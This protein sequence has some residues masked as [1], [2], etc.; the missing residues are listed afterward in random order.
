MAA[1]E[2]RRNE[3]ETLARGSLEGERRASIA[4]VAMVVL[5]AACT[6][7]LPRLRGEEVARDLA[8]QAVG[9]GYMVFAIGAMFALR[10]AGPN[11]R[12][13]RRRP[14]VVTVLDFA[15]I[16]FMGL[17]DV[18]GA[19]GYR[20]ELGA[21]ASSILI[22][23][24]VAR[25]SLWHVVLSVGLAI[26]AFLTIAIH[27]GHA[28]DVGTFFV[29]GG[30]LAL[31]VLVALT[32]RAVRAM[33][34]DL[35]RRDNLTRFLPRPVAERV[36]AQGT[37][38]LAPVMREVT[39]LFSD[40]RGFTTLSETLPPRAV[41]E[42]LDD[43]FGRMAQIV[44]GHDGVVGKFLGDGLLAYWGVP[45]DDADHAP[46]AVRAALDMQRALVELNRVRAHEGAPPLRVGIGVHTGPVA[47]G[48]LGGAEHAEYTVIGD[49]V[50]VASRVEGLTKERGVDVLISE[51][52]WAR[53]GARF[54]G[55]A[56]EP[57]AIRGRR[58]AVGLYAIEPES[59]G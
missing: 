28:G 31:G 24:A 5:F 13:S 45:D 41:L 53:C 29:I 39:V 44:K 37:H 34:Q 10:R 32:N 49:A 50:N 6:E 14:A 27:A 9:L 54:T 2:A 19:L 23:F 15:F 3:E 47:A 43:Y 36:L 8:R 57:A 30:F 42:L 1:F 11:I 48:M 59:L 22:S 18:D 21:A 25:V 20:P 26:V 7:V 55:R 51:T 58:E 12:R 40:I 4:R 38:A 17:S 52:T 56:L 16:T 46:K 33:F 35:R